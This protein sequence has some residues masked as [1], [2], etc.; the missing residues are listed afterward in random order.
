MTKN[1][2]DALSRHLEISGATVRA[3]LAWSDFHIVLTVARSG[4]V[5]QAKSV[6]AMSHV[7]LLRKLDAIETRLKARLFD[8]SRGH[9]TPT[10]AGEAVIEAAKAIEPLAR[11]AEMSV[12]GQDV[13]PSGHVRVTVAGIVI[14]ELIVP[15]LSAFTEAF[16]DVTL[17]FVSSRD[18]ASLA[19]READVAI[20][21]S[22]SVPDWLIGR[23][24]GE[25]DFC[26]FGLH[27]QALAQRQH[28][29]SDL[30]P[31]RRWIVLERDVRDLKFD[32]WLEDHVP[33]SSVV[34]RVD[35]FAHALS[36]VR[37]GLGIALLP[38]FVSERHPELAPLTAPLD[39]L[40]T[41]LWIVTHADLRHTA[42]IRAVMQ[43][44]GQALSEAL[45]KGQ[46]RPPAG[47]AAPAQPRR[48]AKRKAGSP[49][50]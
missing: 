37:A 47:H 4:S 28:A 25:V 27:G 12:L 33:A 3:R 14:D 15:M 7:T 49:D 9:Y 5:S 24:L 38:S 11:T 20:R 35:A 45:G 48:G 41:P 40:R 32:R 6:L 16:P 39:E 19:R 18:H 46:T 30:L 1:S 43:T 36:M 22:D 50:R 21:V 13:R 8:R 34:L 31:Q 10:E 23:R 44:L 2:A 26:I 42:R 29:L 17:E